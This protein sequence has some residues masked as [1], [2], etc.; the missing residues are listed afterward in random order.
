MRSLA[1]DYAAHAIRV[2]AIVP[3]ATETRLMWGDMPEDEIPVARDRTAMQLP[4]GRLALPAE[5][6]TGIVWLLSDAA[7]YATGS[8]LVVDGGLMARASI[9]S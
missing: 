7:G 6:A 8:H 1:I 9:D 4:L 2:N 3:G 5:I